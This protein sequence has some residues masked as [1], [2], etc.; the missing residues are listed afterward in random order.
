[1]AQCEKLGIKLKS[2]LDAISTVRAR[3]LQEIDDLESKLADIETRILQMN[4]SQETLNR[5]YLEL[6][7]MKHVLRET[8]FVFD[9]AQSRAEGGYGGSVDDEELLLGHET[10]PVAAADVEAGNRVNQGGANFVA[11]VISAARMMTFE[12][13]LWRVLRG[14]LYMK[15]YPIDEPIHDPETDELLKKNVFVVFAHGKEILGKIRKISESL[16]ATVYPVDASAA[17]RAE[18]QLEVT[19]RIEDLNNVIHNTKA[20]RR[21]EL[22]KVAESIDQWMVI[23]KKE[24]A[25]YHT[26]N[27]F[28]YDSTRKC[29]ITEGWCPSSAINSIQYALHGASERSGSM[30]PPVLNE[31]RTHMEPPTYH[32]TNKFTHVFQIIIDAYGVA[33]HKEVNPG[34]FTIITFPFLFSLM[35]G[36]FGHG[37]MMTI[38]AI[39]LIWKEKELSKNRGEVSKSSNGIFINAYVDVLNDL[40]WSLYSI[41]YGIILRIHWFDLQ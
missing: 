26:M 11:G 22:V 31:L 3:T 20:T 10:S 29:L 12:R 18:H 7:E 38:F 8:A 24:K 28:N 9:E 13:I 35:F 41:A 30:V 2:P 34:L 16:G 4:A 21:T 17:K 32:R 19:A 14:N 25:I 40:L 37:S 27:L 1:M 36:D 39:W 33:K 5:R 23:V 6:T 15:Y